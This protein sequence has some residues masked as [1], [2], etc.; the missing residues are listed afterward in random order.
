MK[1]I[2]EILDVSA[3]TTVF[4]E[5]HLHTFS[6]PFGADGRVL[7]GALRGAH[8]PKESADLYNEVKYGTQAEGTFK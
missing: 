7:G 1:R 4:F 6:W 2:E 3:A 5:F 8:Q